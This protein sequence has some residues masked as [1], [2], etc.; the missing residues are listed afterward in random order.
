MDQ[1]KEARQRIDQIDEEMA[2]L[3]CERMQ[4]AE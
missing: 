4:E 2:R 3:F 1:L